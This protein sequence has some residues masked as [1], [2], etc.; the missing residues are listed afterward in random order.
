MSFQLQKIF[1]HKITVSNKK[2]ARKNVFWTPFSVIFFCQ[3][4]I[5]EILSFHEME[6]KN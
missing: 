3:F 2:K 1:G 5:G 6:G 4:R